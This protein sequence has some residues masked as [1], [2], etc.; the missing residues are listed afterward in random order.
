MGY[1]FKKEGLFRARKYAVKVAKYWKK[2]GFD[3]KIVKNKGSLPMYKYSL[4][5]R[6][7]RKK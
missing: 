7:K 4:L 6:Y 1:T 2:A 3:T 5:R